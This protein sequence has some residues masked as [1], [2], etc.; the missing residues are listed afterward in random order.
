MPQ[1]EGRQRECILTSSDALKR[2]LQLALTVVVTAF[3]FQ[4]LGL[5]W[6]EF[7]AVETSQ[8]RLAP[9]WLLG[10]AGSALCAYVLSGVLWSRMVV[11]LGGPTLSAVSGVRIFFVANLGRYVPGKVMQLAGMAWLATREGVKPGVALGAAVIGHGTA[12]L[13]AST[14]GLLVLIDAPQPWQSLGWVGLALSALLVAL[15]SFP[16]PA[17]YLQRL[18]LRLAAKSESGADE[19]PVVVVRGFGVRW[20]SAYLVIWLLFALSF[21]LFCLGIGQAADLFVVGPAYAA[22]YVAGYVALFAPA[23]VG[24]REAA[25]VGFLLPV[26]PQDTALGVA[27]AFRLWMTVLEVVPAACFALMTPKAPDDA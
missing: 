11:D 1:P 25:L 14:L 26:M 16:V 8:W 17:A 15:T 9:A 4:R 20:I 13:A 7:R 27:L 22:A 23:G 21:W 12:L 10:S 19:A 5:G 18:W 3:I 24:I 6:A 2:A